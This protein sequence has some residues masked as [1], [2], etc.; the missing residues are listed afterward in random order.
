MHH[1]QTNLVFLVVLKHNNDIL[2]LSFT[3]TY[4]LS[5]SIFYVIENILGTS[6]VQ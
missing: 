3:L 1:I 5:L 4:I 2:F 6:K